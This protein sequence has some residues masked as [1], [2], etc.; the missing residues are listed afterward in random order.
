[1]SHFVVHFVVTTQVDD[2]QHSLQEVEFSFIP[3]KMNMEK[4]L[5]LYIL[6]TIH[7]AVY[8][9]IYLPQKIFRAVS[10]KIALSSVAFRHEKLDFCLAF[11]IITLFNSESSKEKC[12][13]F[14]RKKTHSNGM[15]VPNR[16]NIYLIIVSWKKKKLSSYV[17]HF[18]GLVVFLWSPLKDDRKLSK[19][20]LFKRKIKRAHKT[21]RAFC[22]TFAAV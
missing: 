9:D 12:V 18:Q 8:F 6:A 19:R 7:R 13:S 5:P 17:Y 16:H 15:D 11:Q 3:S 22:R 2:Q 4:T 20:Y 1:M 21:A 10:K 14:W